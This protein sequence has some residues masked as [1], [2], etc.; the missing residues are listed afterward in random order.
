MPTQTR[1]EAEIEEVRSFVENWILYMKMFK[2]AHYGGE[3]SREDEQNFLKLKSLVARK[4]QYLMD[5]LAQ[6]YIAAKPVTKILSL[7]VNLQTVTR[8]NRS[9]YVDIE[10]KWH[11]TFLALNETMGHLRYRLQKGGK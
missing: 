5:S 11:D 8:V 6:D 4:H 9:H 1:T 10:T 3:I 2:K 7:C